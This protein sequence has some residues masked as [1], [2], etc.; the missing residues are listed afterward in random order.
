M[1]KKIISNK[2]SSKKSS[3]NLIEQGL[4][5]ISQ[6]VDSL[7]TDITL[8]PS[9]PVID[10]QSVPTKIN[11]QT[12]DKV[13]LS[14]VNKDIVNQ[15]EQLLRME[16]RDSPQ[17]V[18]TTMNVS[19]DID[20]L[21][22][23][24]PSVS[25]IKGFEFDYF[26]KAVFD[27]FCSLL[28]AGNRYITLAMIARCMSGKSGN[29]NP[30]KTTADNI[31]KSIKKMMWTEICID[32]SEEF[33]NFQ[34]VR[35]RAKKKNN[36]LIIKDRLLNVRYVSACIN[37]ADV[38]AYQPVTVPSLLQYASIRQ[39][40]NSF[41]ATVLSTPGNK[42]RNYMLCQYFLI[43]RICTMKS[44]NM[45]S[46]TI[47]FERIYSVCPDFEEK[48]GNQ[49]SYKTFVTR[50]RKTICNFLEYWKQIKFIKNFQ[51]LSDGSV[52]YYSICIELYEE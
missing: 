6:F 1:N 42:N 22:E 23:Y 14:L 45:V 13:S 12:R 16:K 8:N 33:D 18:T 35:N 46:K 41:D 25:I 37:G 48:K 29:Y 50:L 7:D 39:Q 52:K 47:L 21:I 15:G 10:V 31:H 34:F 4:E 11:I 5:T 32:Y 36:K 3:Y 40:I 24:D 28:C 44:S 51:I 9:V 2:R 17:P 43:Q 26:D 38:E 20:S 49:Y 30:S 19:L 27:A